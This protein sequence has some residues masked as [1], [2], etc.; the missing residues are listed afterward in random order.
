VHEERFIKRRG[1]DGAIQSSIQP[2]AL[3]GL[4]KGSPLAAIGKHALEP[5][6]SEAL[7]LAFELVPADSALGRNTLMHLEQLWG[8]NWEGGGY[9]RYNCS[10]E[11]DT[12]GPW[13]FP[14]LFVAR[15]YAEAKDFDSVWRILRWLDSLPG[16]RS[17]SWFE[18][19]GIPHSP[20]FAQLGVTPWTWS[21]LLLLLVHHILGVRPFHQ[22]L[23]I[24]PN[25]FPTL[26]NV[27]ARFPLREGWLQLRIQRKPGEGSAR[28][29]SNARILRSSSEEVLLDYSTPNIEVDIDLP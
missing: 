28:F 24:R 10:S 5:D 13:P 18:F 12:D 29:R 25:L 7:P 4:P 22:A 26:N 20:P 1:I 3:A 21:E 6:T 8:Q 23:C 15:A 27:E 16:S 19:Y 9:G 14:S 2:Q 17:G 11:P